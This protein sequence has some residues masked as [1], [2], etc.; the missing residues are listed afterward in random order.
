MTLDEA[1][2][3]TQPL[4]AI[5]AEPV[6]FLCRTRRGT[7]KFETCLVLTARDVAATDYLAARVMSA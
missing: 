2:T 6:E 3:V 1:K 7:D 4:S 5:G